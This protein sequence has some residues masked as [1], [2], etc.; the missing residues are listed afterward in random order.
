M[1]LLLALSLV[2]PDALA[3]APGVVGELEQSADTTPKQKAEFVASA[4]AE[5]TAGVATVEKLLETSRNSKEKDK[6]EIQC[7]EEKLPQM[8]TILEVTKKTNTAMESHLAANDMVHA[9]QEYRQVAVLLSRAREFLA[10]AQQCVKG[11]G[12]S[13]GKTASSLSQDDSSNTL[14]DI[15]DVPPDIIDVTSPV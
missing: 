7:L 9:D 12:T 3:A 14:D 5:I 8:K 10:D 13:S 4:L 1:T 11:A 15:D 6:E 2:S